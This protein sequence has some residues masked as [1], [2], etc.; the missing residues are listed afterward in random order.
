MPHST[1]KY[2]FELRVFAWASGFSEA[3][4]GHPSY[5]FLLLLKS[6][7]AVSQLIFG[8]RPRHFDVDKKEA[9]ISASPS[10]LFYDPFD[11][12]EYGFLEWQNFNRSIMERVVRER[13]DDLDFIGFGTEDGQ[14]EF[15]TS[16]TLMQ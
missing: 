5:S 13:F 6:D 14:M 3:M 11:F 10:W 16:W 1:I 12:P 7:G 8:D 9:L 15:P 2:P 4:T